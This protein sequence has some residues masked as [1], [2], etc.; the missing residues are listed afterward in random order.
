M[1]D[2]AKTL[3]A[4]LTNMGAAKVRAVFESTLRVT[5]GGSVHEEGSL[6]AEILR[7][8]S[9]EEIAWL[10]NIGGLMSAAAKNAYTFKHS[11]Q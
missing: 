3:P 2:E 11:K 8:F 10:Y 6:S 4:P 9:D 7:G 1:A 5:Q